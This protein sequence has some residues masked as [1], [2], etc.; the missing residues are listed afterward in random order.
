LHDP[1]I[2]E[3]E[4]GKVTTEQKRADIMRTLYDS[5]MKSPTNRVSWLSSD[6]TQEDFA[7]T[8]RESEW[9]RDHGF[10]EC[11]A[12]VGGVSNARITTKGRDAFEAGKFSEPIPPEAY[13]RS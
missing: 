10:I 4:G 12:S 2:S 9:L 13:S 3:I 6:C 7:D 8:Y 1:G 5:Y 11:S